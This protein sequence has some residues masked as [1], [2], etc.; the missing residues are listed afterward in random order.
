MTVL[1]LQHVDAVELAAFLLRWSLNLRICDIDQPIP[2]SFWGDDE[3]GLIDRDLFA[4]PST[5]LHSIFHEASH[6]ICMDDKRRLVLHTNAG[7]DVAE[8]NAVCYLQ[9]LLAGAYAPMGFEKMFTDMDSWGYSFRL[10]SSRRWFY[11]D[12]DDARDWLLEHDLIDEK[13]RV[14]QRLR[15]VD[16]PF[17]PGTTR[18]A[19]ARQY[20][21]V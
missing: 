20:L 21:D 7:S 4:W 18:V 3:A 17:N 6:F 14:L 16:R 8:E 10:G 12:A 9:V 13:N 2:G 5:P 1:R 19:G 11:E 15:G